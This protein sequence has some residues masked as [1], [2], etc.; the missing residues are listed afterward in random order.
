MME[1]YIAIYN[2]IYISYNISMSIYND[3]FPA[4]KCQAPAPAAANLPWSH[5]ERWLGQPGGVIPLYAD[6]SKAITAMK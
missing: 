5:E 4:T 3:G 1:P 2:H 6:G